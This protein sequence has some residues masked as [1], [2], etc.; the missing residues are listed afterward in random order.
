MIIYQQGNILA[1]NSQ[2]IVIPVNLKGVAGAG[3]ALRWAKEDPEAL[4]EYK[5]FCNYHV[6]SIGQV[7]YIRR[8]RQWVM[9]PTKDDWRNP[10]ELLWIAAGLQDLKRKIKIWELNSIAIPA[11]GCG[12]GGLEWSM[13]KPLMEDIL[14]A[15]DVPISIYPPQPH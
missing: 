3:L 8:K 13:V 6:L 2:A 5:I 9:F 12:L 10:S 7:E 14:D 1:D 4:T 15:V 11:L